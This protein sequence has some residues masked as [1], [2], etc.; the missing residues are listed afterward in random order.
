[1]TTKL[2]LAG[3]LNGGNSN[4]LFHCISWIGEIWACKDN[5]LN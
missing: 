4:F 2:N 1:M 5:G 3:I